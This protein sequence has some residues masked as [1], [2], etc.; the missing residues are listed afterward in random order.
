MPQYQNSPFQVPNLLQKGVASYLFGSFDYK[1]GNT[2]GALQDVALAADVATVTILLISGPRPVVGALISIINSTQGGGEFNVSR[3]P[4]TAVSWT[5]STGSGTVTFALT[6]ANLATVA[7][8]GTV[9]IEPAEVPETLVNNSFSVPIVVQAPEGDSQFTLPLAVTFPTLPNDATVTLQK[10]VKNQ[11]SEFT[12]TGT[13]VTIY[14]GAYT[15]GPVVEATL[16]RGYVYRLAV[17][18]V[19]GNGTIVAKVG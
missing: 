17:T 14:A 4:I 7:D 16:E 8:S 10:A 11:A 5:D 12:N 2:R 9:I 19:T 1:I 3:A 6:G 15:A 13:A 18:S